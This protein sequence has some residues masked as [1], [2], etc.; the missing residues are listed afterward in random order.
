MFHRGYQALPDTTKEVTDQLSM[1]DVPGILG[2][3]Q[4]LSSDVQIQLEN[5]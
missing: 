2:G 5:G 1:L 3:T 4:P